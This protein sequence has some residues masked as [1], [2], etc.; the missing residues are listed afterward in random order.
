MGDEHYTFKLC[1]YLH[2]IPFMY[3]AHLWL[4]K[5]VPFYA[6]IVRGI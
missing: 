1:N 4:Y 2:L 3:V 6:I 5:D